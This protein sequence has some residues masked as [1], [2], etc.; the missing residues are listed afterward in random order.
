MSTAE[1]LSAVVRQVA[2]HEIHIATL[3]VRI[4]EMRDQWTKLEF[5]CTQRRHSSGQA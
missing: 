2:A 4:D 5:V 1:E 3:T